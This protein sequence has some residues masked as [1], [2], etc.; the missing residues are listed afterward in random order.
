MGGNEVLY[1][2][3]DG[4]AIITVNS[5][6]KMNA[7]SVPV[8]DGLLNAFDKVEQDREVRVVVLTGTGRVFVAGAD[9]K[10][11]P[12]KGDIQGARAFLRRFIYFFRRLEKLSKPI[13]AS[14]NGLALGG[15]FEVAL[16][17]DMVVSSDKA[18]FSFPEAGLGIIAAFGLLRLHQTVGRFKAKELLM[19]TDII[20]PEEAHRLGIVSKVVPH[21]ELMEKTL[22]LA[23]KIRD[24]APLSIEGIK[25]GVNRGLGGADENYLM[26]AIPI[27]FNT[28]DIQEGVRAFIEKRRPEFKGC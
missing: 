3:R 22:A 20:G 25:A 5:P 7:L 15:G 1:E 13:I 23:S 11:L 16:Y 10:D 9:L 21:D 18:K 28:N 27:Y 8:Y 2:N 14:V 17:C 12:K 6:E 26:D 19:T 4:V 24:K